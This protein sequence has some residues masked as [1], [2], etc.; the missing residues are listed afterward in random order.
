MREDPQRVAE[1]AADW[2]LAQRETALPPARQAEF[3]AWLRHSPAHVAA[4]FDIARMHADLPSAAQA[5]QASSAQLRAH[6]LRSGAVVVPLRPDVD[7][8]TSVPNPRRVL[9]RRRRWPLAAA[10]VLALAAAGVALRLSAPEQVPATVYAAPSDAPRSV[11]LDDGSVVQLERGGAIAVRYG[12]Q[13]RDIA[14]LRGKAVFDLGHDPARPLRVSVGALVLRDVGTVFGVDPQAG[15]ARVTVLQGRVQ[16]SRDTPA[17]WHRGDL[18][19][20]GTT[21]ADLGRGQQARVDAQGRVLA[22]RDHADI[23][24]ATAWLPA[25]VGVHD[26]SLGEVARLFNAYTTQ[27]LRIADP[28]LAARRVSGVFHL[29]DPEAFVA[30]LGSLPD[31]QVQRDAHA[32]TIRHAP[33]PL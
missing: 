2:Y 12:T 29:R 25:Q 26:R 6:A 1:A 30:Y 22:R 17:W 3:L 7:T 4:Y 32:V 21:L 9:P 10:A 14:L 28:A 13:R 27:P 15:G 11:A 18:P 5:Q 20:E 33:A 31:V 23:A 24:D 8:P 16:V 19:S